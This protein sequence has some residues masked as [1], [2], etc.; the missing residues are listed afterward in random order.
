MNEASTCLFDTSR[1]QY[2]NSV[3]RFVSRPA[4]LW[5]IGLLVAALLVVFF[6]EVHTVSQ[7]VVAQVPTADNAASSNAVATHSVSNLPS[8]GGVEVATVSAPGVAAPAPVKGAS[9]GVPVAITPA[10]VPAQAAAPSGDLLVFKATSTA[11][12]RVSDAKGAVQFEKTLAAGE[13]ATASGELPLAIV[14]GNVA[15]TELL[16]R[17]QAF[18]L[19]E[20]TKNNVARFEVK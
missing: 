5:V 3:L 11:W 1:M 17:G 4:A 18:N 14:V 7:T 19:E 2:G 20:V 16:V 10:T 15:A 13:S 8:A 9:E 6:P 12:V